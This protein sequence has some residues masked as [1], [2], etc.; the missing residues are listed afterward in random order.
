MALVTLLSLLGHV[1]ETWL[2][3]A[4]RSFQQWCCAD[5]VLSACRFVAY[6][7]RRFA[8]KGW[9]HRFHERLRLRSVEKRFLVIRSRPSLRLSW[10]QFLGDL[11]GL[12]CVKPCHSQSV[13]GLQ[14]PRR[15]KM[16]FW[17]N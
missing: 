9:R 11:A 13:S 16:F 10:G 4:S 12:G 7:C 15:L 6:R 17:R 3:K 2:I 14:T 8:R 5:R 1:G